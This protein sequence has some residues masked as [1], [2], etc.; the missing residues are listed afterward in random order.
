MAHLVDARGLACPLPVVNTKTEISK[1]NP[2]E[3][4]ET[5]VDNET[6][7]Q[8][9]RKFAGVK[10][11]S[12]T[13]EKKSDSEYHVFITLGE[14]A[15]PAEAA[16]PDNMEYASCRPE[17]IVVAFGV[18]A[19]GVGPKELSGMLVTSFIFSLTQ[20]EKLP[21]TILFYN[22]G[23]YLTAEGSDCIENLKILESKGVEI[24]TCGTC[25]K[26]YDL[27]EK[28]AVGTV[29]NMYEI[30]EKMLNASHLVRP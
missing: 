30:V 20:Q 11:F 25:I 12:V 16:A 3:T 27:P 6:A 5:I 21:K 23:A 22:S 1:M 19:M 4:V 13:D 15:N 29:T 10:G 8:N 17:N 2:G 28:P 14:N 18:N 26:F 7:V 24:L 9:L